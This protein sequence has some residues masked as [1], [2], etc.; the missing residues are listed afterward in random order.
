M[1]FYFRIFWVRSEGERAGYPATCFHQTYLNF[2]FIRIEHYPR[3]HTVREAFDSLPGAVT[4]TPCL[5]LVPG[6][7]HR[8]GDW[9]G[10]AINAAAYAIGQVSVVS[11]T[12]RLRYVDGARSGRYSIG[13]FQLPLLSGVGDCFTPAIAAGV[14]YEG[15]EAFRLPPFCQAYRFY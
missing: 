7:V 12:R 1:Y 6:M 10:L 3:D 14:V 8:P 9:D 5:I 2:F 13:F 4:R 11:A 15:E